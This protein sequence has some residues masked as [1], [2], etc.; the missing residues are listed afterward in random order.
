MHWGFIA[1]FIYGITKQVDEVEELEDF[2]LL[3]E[4]IAF[5]VLFLLLLLARFVYMQSSRPT[6]IP[7]STPRSL[8]LLA[9]IVHLGM[10][11]SLALIAVTGLMIGGLYWSGVKTGQLM[12]ALLLGHEVV[13]W[14]SINLIAL[15]V[16][17][18]IYHRQKD[19]GIW[20]S[21]LPRRES[22]VTD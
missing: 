6:V 5:A 13:F 20:R 19:D 17:G 10:Y 22:D 8:R 2:T 3:Q 18:A 7:S 12:D 21:M 11:A 4:E 9:R 15:H 16:I 14:V 1:V